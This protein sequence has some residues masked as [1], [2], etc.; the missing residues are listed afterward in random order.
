CPAE[1]GEGPTWVSWLTTMLEP[2]GVVRSVKVRSACTP[3][4]LAVMAKQ[5]GRSLF[6]TAL[7]SSTGCAFHRK[8]TDAALVGDSSRTHRQARHHDGQRSTSVSR[9]QTRSIDAWIT[10]ALRT[11]IGAPEVVRA[12][13]SMKLRMRLVS[14]PNGGR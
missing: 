1:P 8:T 13:R 12:W 4:A 11:S 3:L 9:S 10:A 6:T 5:C 2:S 14:R 7:R